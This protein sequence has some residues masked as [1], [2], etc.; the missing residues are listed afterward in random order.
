MHNAPGKLILIAGLPGSGKSCWMQTNTPV[1]DFFVADDFMVHAYG[2]IGRFTYSRWYFPLLF[3]LRAG[4]NAAISATAFCDFERPK[5]AETVMSDTVK[6]LAYR[7]VFFEHA[8]DA[9]RQNIE[10]G[11]REKGRAPQK[12]LQALEDWSHRDCIPLGVAA[13]SAFR[14][15]GQ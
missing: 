5:A 14:P 9:C 6:D 11:A 1:A 10:R 15:S 13:E 7:W 2:D 3:A 12:R 8:P 4:R